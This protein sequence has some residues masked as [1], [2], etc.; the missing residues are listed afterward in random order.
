MRSGRWSLKH[1]KNWR[2]LATTHHQLLRLGKQ[3]DFDLQQ[4]V[5]YND[6]NQIAQNSTSL[7]VHALARPYQLIFANQ[8]DQNCSRKSLA[9]RRRSFTFDCLGLDVAMLT[10]TGALLRPV[11]A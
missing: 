3:P 1:Q 6:S 10:G 9:L 7:D 4:L 8:L 2:K 5:Y 11:V